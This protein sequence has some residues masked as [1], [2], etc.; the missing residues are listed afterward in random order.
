MSP[1]LTHRIIRCT[2]WFAGAALM[3]YLTGGCT[4]PPNVEVPGHTHP[5]D[6]HAPTFFERK[7]NPDA[8]SRPTVSDTNPPKTDES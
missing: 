1:Q 8:G 2:I 6:T 4:Q 7:S 3:T 5:G